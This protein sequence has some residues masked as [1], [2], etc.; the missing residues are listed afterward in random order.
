MKKYFLCLIAIVIC[1][2]V[3]ARNPH[4][5]HSNK[6]TFLTKYNTFIIGAGI[7][8]YPKESL[9]GYNI[10]GEY[11][12]ATIDLS[13]AQ[14][15]GV[16]VEENMYGSG[17]LSNKYA[18]SSCLIG[19]AWYLHHGDMLFTINPKIGC[20]VESQF[21]NDCYY[22]MSSTVIGRFLE[23]GL[24][25]GVKMDD[26]LFL[27]FGITNKKYTAQV[28]YTFWLEKFPPKKKRATITSYSEWD[29]PDYK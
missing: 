18:M 4:I 22:E 2:N 23:A 13:Y 10:S 6:H 28:G 25:I 19:Y 14:S 24:D 20:C 16:K 29:S 8:I 9:F 3:D 17:G 1:M 15:S 7:C 26:K 21:Y 12:G 27:K 11:M 5:P